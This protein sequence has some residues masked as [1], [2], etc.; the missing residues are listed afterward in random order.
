M[1][2]GDLPISGLTL[3]VSEEKL[4]INWQYH[5]PNDCLYDFILKFYEDSIFLLM[6]RVNITNYI[7][8][9]YNSCMK[10]RIEVTA[11]GSYDNRGNTLI[12]SHVGNGRR[13]AFHLQSYF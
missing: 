5:G 2:S 10:Y 6:E 11:H 12:A 3:D 7:Y 13:M 4:Y 1:I 9:D 8:L